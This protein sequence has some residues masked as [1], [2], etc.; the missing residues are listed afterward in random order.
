M[1]YLEMKSSVRFDAVSTA[2]VGED[3]SAPAIAGLNS[4]RCAS[5]RFAAQIR[6]AAHQ[7]RRGGKQD[8]EEM[9]KHK[10]PANLNVNNLRRQ[11]IRNL[12]ELLDHIVTDGIVNEQ[13][14]QSS[15]TFLLSSQMHSGDVHIT[16]AE[17][18]ADSTNNP[19]L[20][21]V[22]EENHMSVRHNLQW[23]SIH[24]HN[25][26]KL[27]R[28]HRPG[29]SVRFYVGLEL[30]DDKVSKIFWRRQARVLDLNSA[31]LCDMHGVNQVYPL[32][33]HR[34]EQ[35]THDHGSEVVEIHIADLTGVVDRNRLHTSVTNLCNEPRKPRCQILEM[36]I[37]LDL[38]RLEAR[39]IE[40][41]FDRVL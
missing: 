29:Y 19:R 3:L 1:P 25:P 33:Q 27:V 26:R 39:E 34:H 8:Y 23:I 6:D 24:V 41:A 14:R 30:D 16:P 18:G 35:A 38:S 4:N 31:Q 9:T 40:R 5:H 20:V 13:K 32:P 10:P 11:D 37:S 15:A 22:R 36:F 21:V 2:V 28:E 7:D 12:T 17:D